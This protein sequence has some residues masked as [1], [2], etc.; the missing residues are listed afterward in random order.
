MKKTT[1]GGITNAEFCGFGN[2]ILIVNY[3]SVYHCYSAIFC[4]IIIKI[5]LMSNPILMQ[6]NNKTNKT[7]R[8]HWKPLIFYMNYINIYISW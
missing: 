4:V 3:L 5:L 2:Q 6:N 8:K 7:F 1:A